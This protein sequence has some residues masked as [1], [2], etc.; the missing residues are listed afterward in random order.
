M[1]VSNKAYQLVRSKYINKG[2]IV[3]DEGCIAYRE[4]IIKGT[5]HQYKIYEEYYDG[6]LYVSIYEDEE[7]IEQYEV[8]I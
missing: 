3:S 5:E 7:L 2:E 8:R 1:R 4:T 6:E